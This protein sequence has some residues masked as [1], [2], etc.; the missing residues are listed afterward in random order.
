MLA[1]A[2]SAGASFA[3]AGFVLYVAIVAVVLRLSWA[4]SPAL[5]AIGAAFLTYAALVAI[6]AVSGRNAN[7]WITSIIFWFP[8]LGFLMGFGAVYKSVSL[9][10]LLDLL[11][12]PGERELC[13]AILE[14]YIAVESFENRLA[15]MLESGLAIHTSAGYAL[16]EKGRRLAR[17]T[18]AMHRLFAIERTG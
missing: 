6:A 5:V 12:R 1:D 4:I 7:F 2:I 13:S 14:R 16:T 15:I 3:A 8:T 11:A 18:A 10:I 9:R 17:I